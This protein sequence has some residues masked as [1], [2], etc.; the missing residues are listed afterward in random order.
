MVSLAVFYAFKQKITDEMKLMSAKVDS[1]KPTK[2]EKEDI[3]RLYEA[4]VK[5]NNQLRAEVRR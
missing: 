2:N 1:L 5:E 3:Y 4:A